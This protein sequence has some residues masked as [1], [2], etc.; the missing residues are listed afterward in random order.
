M[1]EIWKDVEGYEGIY[2]ISNTGKLKRILPYFYRSGQ[3]TSKSEHI[4]KGHVT[5]SNYLKFCLCREDKK[6]KV[7]AHRLVAKHFIENPENKRCVNHIDCNPS[8][9]NVENLEWCTHK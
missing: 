1:Q 2:K 6:E 4:T 9:N 7:Y 8:N 5:H 3:K